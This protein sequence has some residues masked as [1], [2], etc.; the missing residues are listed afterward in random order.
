MRVF[1]PHAV[2]LT[3]VK[4]AGLVQTYGLLVCIINLCIIMFLQL[5]Y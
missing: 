3:Q 4:A 5:S 1:D 2:G